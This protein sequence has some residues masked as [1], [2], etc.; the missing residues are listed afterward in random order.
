ME[1][2]TYRFTI[3]IG[4]EG[5]LGTVVCTMHSEQELM[6]WFDHV[7][8]ALDPSGRIGTTILVQQR[9]PTGWRTLRKIPW[10]DIVNSY[11]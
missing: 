8:G 1:A 3:R 5:M 7:F 2:G 4:H 11:N 10:S 9:S 6:T